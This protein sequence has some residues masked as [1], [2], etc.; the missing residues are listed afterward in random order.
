MIKYFSYYFLFILLMLLFFRCSDESLNS[1]QSTGE[2]VS[3]IQL[4]IEIEYYESDSETRICNKIDYTVEPIPAITLYGGKT[5][6]I[7]ILWIH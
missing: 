3:S 2:T 6:V 5:V 1:M 4:C 7:P